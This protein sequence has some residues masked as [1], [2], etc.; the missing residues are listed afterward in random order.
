MGCWGV[1]VISS[2]Q[3][4]HRV[5]MPMNNR[6]ILELFLGMPR[7]LRKKD[8]VHKAIMKYMNKD[9]VEAEVE[10]PN[11]YFHNYRIWM[12]KLYYWFR[13]A[14]YRPMK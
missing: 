3:L 1:S 10:I 8:L 5:S 14:F 4:Y 13:T 12:E 6:K 2:Q 7:E 9:V 11:L